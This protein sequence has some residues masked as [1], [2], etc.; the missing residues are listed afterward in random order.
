[1]K[2][3]PCFLF[4]VCENSCEFVAPCF[5]VCL[6]VKKKSSGFSWFWTNKSTK[7]ETRNSQHEEKEKEIE[8]ER[9]KTLQ[10]QQQKRH[11]EPK[12]REIPKVCY[13]HN[14][15][16]MIV[17]KHLFCC[18]FVAIGFSKKKYDD[19]ETDLKKLRKVCDFHF[20]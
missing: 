14:S 2:K 9:R 16:S 15:K 5:F 7:T 19:P 3:N 12:R 13:F 4:F 6:F 10:K 8:Q 17:T 1:M 18:F 20:L 11:Q